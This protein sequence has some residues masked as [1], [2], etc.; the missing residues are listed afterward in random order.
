MVVHKFYIDKIS[1]KGKKSIHPSGP[2][3]NTWQFKLSS[4]KSG[5]KNVIFIKYIRMV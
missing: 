5:R 1:F 2:K 4:F 3:E